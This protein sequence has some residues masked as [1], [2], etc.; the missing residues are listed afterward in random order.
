MATTSNAF[1][2][3]YIRPAGHGRFKGRFKGLLF[4]VVISALLTLT[5]AFAQ[6]QE[7]QL[8]ERDWVLGN[9]LTFML[10]EVGH[11]LVALW[12][13]PV[14][15]REEDAVDSF[16]VTYLLD[17]IA[18]DKSLGPEKIEQLDDA[19]FVA[20]GAWLAFA[21]ES[22]VEDVSL[23]ADEHSLDMQRFFAHMCL[24]VGR[25]PDV[26]GSWLDDFQIDADTLDVER[27]EETA[28]LQ[29]E[30]WRYLLE[31]E[32][33]E[34]WKDQGRRGLTVVIERGKTKAHRRFEG[35]L[36]DWPWL[37]YFEQRLESDLKLPEPLTLR[38]GACDEANAYYD[39]EAREVVICYELMADLEALF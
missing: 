17:T 1:I 9:V 34:S 16:A 38:F 12:A 2:K 23:Y 39:H 30:D 31:V 25:E 26:Y 3:S 14:L 15:G 36:K 29:A 24:L 19:L 20:A 35:W 28:L 27:C 32:R 33:D 8:D 11:G 37:G 10:H 18:Q 7:R 6:D 22:D 13:L 5:P 4:S 21:E